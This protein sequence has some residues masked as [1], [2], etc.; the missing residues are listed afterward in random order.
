[1]IVIVDFGISSNLKR[2]NY[3]WNVIFGIWKEKSRVRG[4]NESRE[5]LWKH[6]YWNNDGEIFQTFN[7]A[8]TF[9]LKLLFGWSGK[10]YA[11]I[12]F[13]HNLKHRQVWCKPLAVFTK[14]HEKKSC[15]RKFLGR[16]EVDTDSPRATAIHCA[17]PK[18]VI[19]LKVRQLLH[20]ERTVPRQISDSKV[21]YLSAIIVEKNKHSW[22]RIIFRKHSNYF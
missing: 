20:D 15:R 16:T 1:M 5:K 7:N 19:E 13:E 4:E 21:Q 14:R 22:M 6:F 10:V 12:G 3:P 8:L 9:S 18:V 2:K 17:W 11:N